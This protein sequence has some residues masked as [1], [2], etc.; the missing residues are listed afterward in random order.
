MDKRFFENWFTCLN[1]GLEKMSGEECSRL[2]SECAKF[3]SHD[4]LINLYLTLFN[5]CGKNF[6]KFFP[7]LSEKKDLD[8]KVIEPG[9]VYELT[10]TKCGCPLHSQMNV[11]SERLCECS[12]QSMICVFNSLAPEKE[13]KIERI[14]SILAGGEKCIHRI[15]IE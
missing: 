2:F 7:R 6:D 14:E 10:F 9:K 12:T 15:T 4:A 5:E 3:C 1:D 13:I 8:G 11:N